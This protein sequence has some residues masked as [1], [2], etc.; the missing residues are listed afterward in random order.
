MVQ[1]EVGPRRI[2]EERTVAQVKLWD[3]LLVVRQDVLAI[4]PGIV[5]AVEDAIRGTAESVHLELD[6]V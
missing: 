4:L 6:E 5:H 1:A 3:Q 2:Q